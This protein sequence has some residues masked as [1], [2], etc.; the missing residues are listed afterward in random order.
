[1]LLFTLCFFLAN[2]IL[3]AQSE[4]TDEVGGTVAIVI[5]SICLGLIGL[6]LI[7][8][9]IFHIALLIKGTTTREVLKKNKKF[10][11]ETN[12]WCCA[13]PPLVNYFE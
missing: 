4:D 13:D 3:F 6:Q 2:I 9:F 8:F 1:M 5:C 12:Q 7:G 11:D 10:S